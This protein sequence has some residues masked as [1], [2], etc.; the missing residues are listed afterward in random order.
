MPKVVY[1]STKGLYQIDGEGFE[2]EGSIASTGPL[3]LG[4]A[5]KTANY[6]LG[7]ESVIFG[8]CT[9][10]SITF[11][12]PLGARTGTTF[13]IKKIDITENVLLLSGTS[14]DGQSS[15]SIVPSNTAVTVVSSGSNWYII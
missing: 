13:Q 1:T 8:D 12:L 6:T 3:I 5:T 11:T 4:I 15:L 7:A 14:I 2:I 10:G 9:S